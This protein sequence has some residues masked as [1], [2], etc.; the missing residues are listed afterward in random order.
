MLQGAVESDFPTWSPHVFHRIHHYAVII[1][2]MA[3]REETMREAFVKTK[4]AKSM[5]DSRRGYVAYLLRLWQVTNV[6]GTAWRA[7]LQS[8]YN[9]ER[10]GFASIEELILFLRR[11]TGEVMDSDNSKIGNLE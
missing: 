7:S 3:Y 11:E 2:L 8:P 1:L 4:P 6:E 5:S 9:R 10:I